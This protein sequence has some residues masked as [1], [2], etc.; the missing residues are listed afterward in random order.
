MARA[1]SIYV[2]LPYSNLEPVAAFT[3][4]HECVTWL[5]RQ[6]DVDEFQVLTLG[7]GLYNTGLKKTQPAR[8]FMEGKK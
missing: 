2:V 3:V 8:D 7:D 5:S 4:K 1:S 6:V